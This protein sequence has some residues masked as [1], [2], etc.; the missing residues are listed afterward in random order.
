MDF[1]PK[2]NI[3]KASKQQHQLEFTLLPPE[4]ANDQ[5]FEI[6]IDNLEDSN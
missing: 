6:C 4:N 2:S 5:K 3:N 1:C